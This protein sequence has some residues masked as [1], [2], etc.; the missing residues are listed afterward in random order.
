MLTMQWA[1]IFGAEKA[2]V[3]DI[4]DERLELAERLGADYGINSGR[5][6][7]M[8]RVKEITGGRGS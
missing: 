3:F 5:E 1:K 4:L 6:D 7:F 2:V 8:E